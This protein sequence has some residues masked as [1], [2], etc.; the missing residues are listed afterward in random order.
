MLGPEMETGVWGAQEM[1][2]A[3]P[4]FW[5]QFLSEFKQHGTTCQHSV[6]YSILHPLPSFGSHKSVFECAPRFVVFLNLQIVAF[7]N[8]IHDSLHV[9][10]LFSNYNPFFLHSILYP[11]PSNFFPFH[12]EPLNHPR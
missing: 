3:Q 8:M 2:W 5:N 12:T 1:W 6:H 11:S 7:T 10:V 4:H 9:Y